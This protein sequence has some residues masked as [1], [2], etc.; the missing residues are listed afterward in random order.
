MFRVLSYPSHA[1]F[2]YVG[3]FSY[4]SRAVF[5]F[6]Q[7]VC[8]T[9]PVLTYFLFL[10]CLFVCLG[11]GGLSLKHTVLFSVFVFCFC[12]VLLDHFYWGSFSYT[13]CVGFILC[14]EFLL[15]IPCCLHFYVESFSYTS[16]A[17]F[18]FSFFFL[19]GGG[20]F[21][22]NILC[23]FFFPFFY[24]FF[25]GGVSFTHPV[26]ASFLCVEFLLHILC[27]LYFSIRSFSYTSHAGLMFIWGVSLTHPVLAS[28]LSKEFVLH[29]L[30][31]LYF[32]FFFFFFFF[33]FFWGGGGG[34]L[35]LKHTVL[36]FYFYF[37]K[38]LSGGVSLTHPV[39]ASFLCGEFLLHIP[40][41]LDVYL[42]SFSD[43]SRAG[44]IFL[45]GEF[46]LH[47][48][49]WFHFYLGVSL[50]HPVLASFLSGEFYLLFCGEF[51]L[52]IPCEVVVFY[53]G[54]FSYTS[55]ADFI[56][57]WGVS[58]T[59]PALPSFLCGKFLLHIPCWL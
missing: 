38:F 39:L 16:R 47:I 23:F 28:F 2:F 4:T 29:I 27:W 37:F 22:L 45:S 55:H 30:C 3:S 19:G 24:L 6:K 46:L 41:W 52:H 1:D 13:S 7:G 35:S 59:H 9:Y 33:F 17:E 31:F 11:G 44:F 14:P 50:T 8:L 54:S 56:F 12:F 43:T 49:C 32:I 40:R 51:L 53:V 34:G 5:I 25:I 42:G 18:F 21:L 20:D 26:L 48:P 36:F 15:H 57:M 58:L 10:F